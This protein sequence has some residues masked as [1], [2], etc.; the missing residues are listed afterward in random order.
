[1]A[2]V[3]ADE[4]LAVLRQQRELAAVRALEAGR[5]PRSARSRPA[6]RLTGV[7]SSTLSQLAPASPER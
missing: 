3:G 4:E 6:C 7:P 5:S 2:V 1:V